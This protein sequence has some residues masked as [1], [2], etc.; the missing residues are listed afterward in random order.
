[1]RILFCVALLFGASPARA[2]TIDAK[3]FNSPDQTLIS[4]SGSIELDDVAKFKARTALFPKGIVALSGEDGLAAAGMEIG[5]AIRTK[6]FSTAIPDGA[7]CASACALAWLAGAQ[8]HMGRA[9]LV[10][11]PTEAGALLGAYLGRIGLSDRAVSNILEAKPQVWLTMTDANLQGV[12]ASLFSFPQAS[13]E[14]SQEARQASP[15]AAEPSPAAFSAE[16]EDMSARLAENFRTRFTEAGLP[17]VNASVRACLKRARAARAEDIT[18]YCVA[19]DWMATRLDEDASNRLQ[20]PR[21]AF[22]LEE[23]RAK[24]LAE[25]AQALH[26]APE[27]LGGRGMLIGKRA[28]GLTPP[29]QK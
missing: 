1:V 17:G 23:A 19:L 5:A 16:D 8:R 21:N 9:A 13:Q 29:D 7:R 3:P 22:N 12:D 26:A 11:F 28:Y 27:E 18:R 24:R 25:L 10:A 4:V 15:P 14:L 6:G 20:T 2:A